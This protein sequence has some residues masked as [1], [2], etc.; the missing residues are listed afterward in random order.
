MCSWAEKKKKKKKSQRNGEKVL[1]DGKIG[2]YFP[3]FCQVLY[4]LSEM[5]MFCYWPCPWSTDSTWQPSVSANYNI[6]HVPAD[7]AASVS[8]YVGLIS[9]VQTPEQTHGRSKLYT[10]CLGGQ[11]LQTE[12][13]CIGREKSTI[14]KRK[15]LLFANVCFCFLIFPDD[16]WDKSSQNAE[17]CKVFFSIKET[18]FV[19]A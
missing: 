12:F 15:R 3:R 16:D 1:L 18:V 2:S 10:T 17:I 6:S 4:V 14:A 19:I 11:Y 9:A 5:Y 13:Q 8:A 7:R